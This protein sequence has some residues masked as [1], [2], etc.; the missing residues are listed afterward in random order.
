MMSLWLR[1][2]SMQTSTIVNLQKMKQKNKSKEG[3][4][5]FFFCTILE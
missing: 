1:V 5:A 3:L 2:V 4:T